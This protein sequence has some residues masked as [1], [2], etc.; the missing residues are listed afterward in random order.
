MANLPTMARTEFTSA[1]SQICAERGIDPEVVLETIKEAILAAFRKETHGQDEEL[2]YEVELDPETGSARLF[3]FP[4]GKKK[5]I[6]KDKLHPKGEER[7]RVIGKTKKGR[8]LFVVFTIRKEKIRII[9]ARDIN[10]KEVCL[11]EEKT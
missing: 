3:S 6:F 4:E 2:E 9:S 5:K 1:L 8:L 7:F 10:R 11:Y